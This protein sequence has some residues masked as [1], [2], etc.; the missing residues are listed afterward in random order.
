MYSSL[1][2]QVNGEGVAHMKGKTNR[3]YVPFSKNTE[4]L[5]RVISVILLTDH[6]L[7][8][9]EKTKE[10]KKKKREKK[11]EKEREERRREEKRRKEKKRKGKE[12]KER[13]RKEKKKEKKRKKKR[14]HME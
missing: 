1:T 13:K 14:K 10:K 6:I 3:E 8:R 11:K 9:G 2:D 12:R 5:Y 4:D 7:S